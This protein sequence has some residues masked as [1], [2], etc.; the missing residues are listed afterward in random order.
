M[1]E[2]VT[3]ASSTDDG[4]SVLA[5]QVGAVARDRGLTIAVA[6]SLTG[7]SLTASLAAAED[8]STW[9]RGGVVAY[10]SE[11]KHDVLQVRPGPV[12]SEGAAV[13]LAVNVVQLLGSDIGIAITG[14][15][16]PDPQDGEPPG[17][18]WAAV[19]LDGS[20][21]TRLWH[22]QGEPPDVVRGAIASALR[23]TAEVLG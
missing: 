17:T 15:G 1:T 22:L 20:T 7:G 21:T 23:L 9:L 8:A 14:V 3:D 6:E 2:A 13:D 18:V 5:E 10:A 12:V 19:H 11:V 4:S 16:G